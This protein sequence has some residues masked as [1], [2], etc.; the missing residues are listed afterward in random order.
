M[1]FGDFFRKDRRNKMRQRTPSRL[2]AGPGPEAWNWAA[3]GVL[4]AAS[5][6]DAHPVCDSCVSSGLLICR[7]VAPETAQSSAVSRTLALNMLE[8]APAAAVS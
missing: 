1:S 2:A 4:C 3:T 8:P 7:D 5:P 6:R